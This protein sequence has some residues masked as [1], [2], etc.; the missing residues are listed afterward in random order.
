MH[1]HCYF[2]IARSPRCGSDQGFS[3]L[4]F[5]ILYTHVLVG[6]RCRNVVYEPALPPAFKNIKHIQTGRLR[7][8]EMCIAIRGEYE[9]EK[10]DSLR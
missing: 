10:N 9:T 6:L 7:R 1:F 8:R 2:V 3:L 5:T 4:A